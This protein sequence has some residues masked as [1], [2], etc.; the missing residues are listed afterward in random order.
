M[1]HI[2]AS[3]RAGNLAQKIQRDLQ[4][5][6]SG[7]NSPEETIKAK[8]VECITAAL[9]GFEPNTEVQV[10][11]DANLTNGSG[12]RLQNLQGGLTIRIEQL[13]WSDQGYQGQPQ[14]SQQNR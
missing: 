2:Y 7:T 10:Q 4:S 11:V 5:Q 14:G 12:A 3:D 6:R 1:F 9:H 8:V 13:G